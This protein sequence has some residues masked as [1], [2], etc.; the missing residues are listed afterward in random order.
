MFVC[1]SFHAPAARPTRPGS[2]THMRPPA[3]AT[4]A[5]PI[6]TC[7]ELAC[8]VRKCP[9]NGAIFAG[10]HL[11][12]GERMR[13]L[14]RKDCYISMF[15]CSS[16][17]REGC[18]LSLLVSRSWAPLCNWHAST[19]NLQIARAVPFILER[20]AVRTWQVVW[21]NSCQ[22]ILCAAPSGSRPCRLT[23][24]A[25]PSHRCHQLLLPL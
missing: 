14:M 12:A 24:G 5:Q 8:V 1:G 21:A 25:C 6:V 3:V 13:T 4:R 10:T 2:Q 22:E 9:R 11:R 17:A 7:R 19:N 15:S 20:R 16:S 18:L 23:G